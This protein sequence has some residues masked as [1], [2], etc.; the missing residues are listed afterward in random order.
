MG[1]FLI[2]SYFFS[3]VAIV[4]C[5]NYA[6]SIC[7]GFSVAQWLAIGHRICSQ[8]PRVRFPV[9]KFR[10]FFFSLITFFLYFSCIFFT[11]EWNTMIVDGCFENLKPI[12][13]V[14]ERSSAS[15]SGIR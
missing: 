13:K 12:S 7:V 2:F 10:T 8:L 14:Y 15:L 3:R 6:R 1:S 11:F 9:E 4:R 5:M